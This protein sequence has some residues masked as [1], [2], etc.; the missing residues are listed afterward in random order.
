MLQ[1]NELFTQCRRLFL[2]DYCADVLIGILP[3]EQQAK[4]S[5]LFNIDLFVPLAFSSS[6]NDAIE[7]VLDYNIIIHTIQKCISK[8]YNLQET[9]CDE[10]LH[11]FLQH[12]QICAVRVNICKL[13]AYTQAK[14]VGVE[15]FHLKKYA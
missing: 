7:D 1:Y 4:Q 10:L 8:Q 11:N 5:M 3:Q 2:H 12:A 13:H 14:A 15:R 6:V 9:L